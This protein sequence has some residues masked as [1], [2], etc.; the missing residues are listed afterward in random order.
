M[1]IWNTKLGT[2][3]VFF[4]PSGFPFG[5][6]P[7]FYL[8]TTNMIS[9]VFLDKIASFYLPIPRNVTGMAENAIISGCFPENGGVFLP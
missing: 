8:G 5:C 9:L 7:L 3:I 4:A 1:V 2:D 6:F